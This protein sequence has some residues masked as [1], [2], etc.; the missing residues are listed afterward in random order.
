MDAMDPD[1]IPQAYFL[2]VSSPWSLKRPLKKRR[3]LYFKLL[4]N[5]FIFQLYEGFDG[6]KIY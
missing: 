5:I 6:E 3:R 4:E 2:E 1:P